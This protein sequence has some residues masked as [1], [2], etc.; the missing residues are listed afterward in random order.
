M[1][2][3]EAIRHDDAVAASKA[4]QKRMEPLVLEQEDIVNW[5]DLTLPYLG[6]YVPPGW[7]LLTDPPPMF[8]DSTGCGRDDELA[9]SFRRFRLRVESLYE[10]N[11]A[12]GY[13]ITSCG[14]CQL[15]V[16]IYLKEPKKNKKSKAA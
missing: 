13:G 7:R 10:E 8:C 12:F 2:S 4:A 14:P 9:L 3:L 5:G 6:D 1:K 15:Y 11:P 16:G